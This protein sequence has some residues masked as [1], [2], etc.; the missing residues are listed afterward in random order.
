[1]E[2]CEELA[3]NC[4]KLRPNLSK[5]AAETDDKGDSLGILIAILFCEDFKASLWHFEPIG[6][7][8]QTSDELSQVLERY[9]K[10]RKISKPLSQVSAQ[11]IGGAALDL[12]SLDP[13]VQTQA[14]SFSVLDDQLLSIGNFLFYDVKI[15]L[16][17]V[18]TADP[19]HTTAPYVNLL[20][21]KKLDP[22]FS[23]A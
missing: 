3:S 10:F 19:C 16:I 6:E 13:I 15:Q 22:P 21:P 18:V 2:L 11:Q 8:L 23:G 17:C 1:M 14:T 20:Q 12:L 5:L 4:D 7:I 9:E